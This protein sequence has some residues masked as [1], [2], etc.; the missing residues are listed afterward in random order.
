[1]SVL[2]TTMHYY[3]FSLPAFPCCLVFPP[4]TAS[5]SAHY[6]PASAAP[7]CLSHTHTFSFHTTRAYHTA[8]SACHYCTPTT[9]LPAFSMLPYH[10][11]PPSYLPATS[12]LYLLPFTLPFLP[13]IPTT[14]AENQC[15]Y[16]PTLP[17]PFL[18][19]AFYT[20]FAA[21]PCCL[22]QQ[23]VFCTSRKIPLW[24]DVVTILRQTWPGAGGSGALW[25]GRRAPHHLPAPTI[26]CQERRL[27]GAPTSPPS[28]FCSGADRQ[29]A[30][31]VLWRPY[32]LSL[33]HTRDQ[34][35]DALSRDRLGASDAAFCYWRFALQRAGALRAVVFIPG[36]AAARS[37]RAARLLLARRRR[38]GARVVR[39]SR[40]V[41]RSLWRGVKHF[42]CI[43]R[44]G[45]IS[46][47][48]RR[49]SALHF[50]PYAARSALRSAHSAPRRRR[51]AHCVARDAVFSCGGQTAGAPQPA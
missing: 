29:Q 8:P 4:F 15:A 41:G 36:F 14:L 5:L 19:F 48:R 7:S 16:H 26:R 47:K 46:L 6:I 43:W 9:L 35:W 33:P 22:A 11:S 28:L 24:V 42:T 45:N 38:R 1:M 44:R 51:R 10:S 49:A 34:I 31:G 18:P 50:A 37:A 23:L 39:A 3:I 40:L 13:F 12:C 30:C 27:P 2:P 25:A 20:L 21:L 32:S 17:M